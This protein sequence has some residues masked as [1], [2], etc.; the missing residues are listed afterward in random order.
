VS[1]PDNG[2]L[3]IIRLTYSG[4]ELEL[5]LR[6]WEVHPTLTSDCWSKAMEKQYLRNKFVKALK[7][8]KLTSENA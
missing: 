4:E 8:E 7:A 5:Y 6:A 1:Q 2:V 3:R